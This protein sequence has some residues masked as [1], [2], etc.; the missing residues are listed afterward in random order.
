MRNGTLIFN[1]NVSLLNTY[2]C[3]SSHLCPPQVFSDNNH[4]YSLRSSSHIC[5]WSISQSRRQSLQ[6]PKKR[7][8]VRENSCRLLPIPWACWIPSCWTGFNALNTV[9]HFPS[10]FPGA[11]YAG[12]A[13][14][15]RSAIDDLHEYPITQVKRSMVGWQSLYRDKPPSNE[16]RL[17]GKRI[18]LSSHIIWICSI[19]R[20]LIMCI[21]LRISGVRQV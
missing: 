11:F 17:K 1:G 15:N 4:Q 5:R 12:Y 10:W 16:Y 6:R 19:K 3:A 21:R 18:L 13:R 9:R 14:D 2:Q 8:R 7:W 20:G